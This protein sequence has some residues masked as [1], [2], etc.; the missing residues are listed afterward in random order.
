M[1][2]VDPTKL[3]RIDRKSTLLLQAAHQEIKPGDGDPEVGEM[4]DEEKRE[5]E[6]TEDPGID[7]IGG[8]FSAISGT[9]VRARK[10]SEYPS[11]DSSPKCVLY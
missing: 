4:L 11:L 9:V 3:S 6:A 10:R 7:A 5:I 1:S 8:R 2:R